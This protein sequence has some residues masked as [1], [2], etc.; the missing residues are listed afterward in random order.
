LHASSGENVIDD[1][2]HTWE[3]TQTKASQSL[4]PNRDRAISKFVEVAR[5]D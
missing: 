4:L 1:W 3:S 2:R 5:P